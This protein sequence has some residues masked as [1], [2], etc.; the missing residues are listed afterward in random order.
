MPD[1]MV[2][3][4]TFD[5]PGMGG[6]D[7]MDDM[8]GMNHGAESSGMEM[9]IMGR[10]HEDGNDPP[11]KASSMKPEM[12]SEP[13]TAPDGHKMKMPSQNL[14]GGKKYG[15]DFHLLASDASA[16]KELAIDGMNDERPWPPYEKL[17]AVKPTG[18]RPG[19]TMREI[20]LTLDGDMERYVWFLNNKPLSKV[21]FHPHP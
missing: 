6:M 7:H 20:R 13:A 11:H 8:K 3:A 5:Q 10:D 17:R 1:S 14:R 16:S 9:K 4:G 19:R 15:S 2:A 12:P 21:G 18:F